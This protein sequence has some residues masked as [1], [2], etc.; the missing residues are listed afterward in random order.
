MAKRVVRNAFDRV[1]CPHPVDETLV[2]RVK[3]EF[4][5]E[6]NI[7]SIV[8]KMKNGI[9]PPSWMTS[10]TPYYG[11]FVNAPATYQDA[12]D[13]VSRAHEAFTSLPLEFR[14]EIDHDPRNLAH[15]PRELFERFGLIKKPEGSGSGSAAPEPKVGQRGKGDSDLPGTGRPGPDKVVSKKPSDQSDQD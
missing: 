5:K 12:F 2:S 13:I 3:Q 14:R 15:A 1:S 9:S 11:D 4:K 7:N 6:V 10:R 8:N